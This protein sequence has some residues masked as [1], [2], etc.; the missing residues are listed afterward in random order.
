MAEGNAQIASGSPPQYTEIL[1]P[2]VISASSLQ[3]DLSQISPR[4]INDQ[5]LPSPP[6]P[7]IPSSYLRVLPPFH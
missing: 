5:S 6:R 2:L 7:L 1:L 3:I 4:P